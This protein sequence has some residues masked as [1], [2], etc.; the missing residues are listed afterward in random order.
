MHGHNTPLF[1]HEL[2]GRHFRKHNVDLVGM[3][4][5][6]AMA[7]DKVYILEIS[8]KLALNKTDLI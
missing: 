1:L 4:D 8:R 6:M 3:V 7:K 5:N 2:A